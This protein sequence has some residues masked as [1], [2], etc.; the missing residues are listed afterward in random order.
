MGDRASRP[1]QALGQAVDT[2]S[3]LFA[4]GSLLYEM[5]TGTHPFQSSTPLETMQRVVRHR[6][7]QVRRLRRETP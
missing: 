1:G 2:R 5:L 3:D 7:P 4:L 6:P